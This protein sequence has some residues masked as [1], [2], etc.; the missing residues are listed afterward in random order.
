M[1]NFYCITKTMKNDNKRVYTF[2]LQIQRF[3]HTEL[4]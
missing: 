1:E 2:F 3:L 4:K